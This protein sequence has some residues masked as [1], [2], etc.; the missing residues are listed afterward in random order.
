MSFKNEVSSDEMKI[1][2]QYAQC[3]AKYNV[4]C[5]KF[6]CVSQT[7]ILD[8]VNLQ[9]DLVSCGANTDSLLN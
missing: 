6:K 1:C 5:K 9:V 4:T 7:S 2:K 3:F 8:L